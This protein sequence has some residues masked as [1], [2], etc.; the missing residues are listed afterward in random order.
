MTLT[1]EQKEKLLPVTTDRA[2]LRSILS[3]H[4]RVRVKMETDEKAYYDEETDRQATRNY[5]REI[6][7]SDLSALTKLLRET[8]TNQVRYDPSEYV[9]PWVT[10]GQMVI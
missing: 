1:Y 8:H 6:D 10:C 2:Y 3:Q 5:Y 9:Y 7:F 4:A